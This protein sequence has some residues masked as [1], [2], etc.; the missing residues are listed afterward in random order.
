MRVVRVF[1]DEDVRYGL[2]DESSVT[3]ISD[4]PF[5]AWEPEGVVSLPH[6]Q[7]LA[8]VVPTKVVCAGINYREHAREMGHAIPDEPV[9]FLKPPTSVI[10]HGAEI[11][12]PP[13]LE[14][15]DYEAE[16]A[17]VLGRRT[18]R[19]SPAEVSAHVLGYLCA[20]D[21]TSRVLQRKDGQWTRA[22]GFDTFCPLGPWVETDIDPRDVRIQSLVNGEIRQ[23]ARTSD[24]IFDPFELVSFVS[25]VMTLLPGDVVLTGTP[26]GIGAVVAGD[27]VEVRI[28]GIGSLINRVV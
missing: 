10:G 4:E 3:L 24:M 18:H 5:A 12:I 19:A 13:G 7:L 2:A 9:I 27:V 6:A 20:N 1:Q 16:L 8:P 22:K 23:D 28:E 14:S 15:V 21:V 25:H 26:A 11:R 17:V